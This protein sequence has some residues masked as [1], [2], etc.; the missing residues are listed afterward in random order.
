MTEELRLLVRT[1]REV[2]EKLDRGDG[3]AARLLNDPSVAEA[4]DDILVGVN[5]SRL[6][7]WL[8]R[9]RQKA[10]IAQR[11]AAEKAAADRPTP[12][13]TPAPLTATP[14]PDGG[15]R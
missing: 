8:V 14:A 15:L 13:S 12:E 10:G 3:T 7:R 1:L 6:L 2:A 5:E 11:F 9:N 4:L